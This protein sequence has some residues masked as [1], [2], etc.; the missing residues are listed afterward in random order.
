MRSRLP[1]STRSS[2]AGCG[3]WQLLLAGCLFPA[4]PAQ[5]SRPLPSPATVAERSGFTATSRHDDVLAFLAALRGLPR[6]NVMRVET[7]GTSGEGKPL[8]LVI[9]SDPPL[10]DAAAVRRSG[11]LRILINAGD[12]A[13]TATT[14]PS[15][16]S[17][18]TTSA[19]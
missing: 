17:T 12:S 2:A 8:P 1:L 19:R 15:S 11:K 9:V 16:T 4:A 13:S 18:A 10:A 14:M 7:F 6:A 3:S 5:D